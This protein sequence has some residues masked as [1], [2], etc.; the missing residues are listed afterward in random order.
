MAKLRIEAF[1]QRFRPDQGSAGPFVGWAREDTLGLFGCEPALFTD[2]LRSQARS[3]YEGGLIRFLGSGT[4]PPLVGWNG[5]DGWRS[6]WPDIECGLT[7]FGY[8]WMGR[9]YALD[10]GRVI[11][12]EPLVGRLNPA[13]GS[14][15]TSDLTFAEFVLGDLIAYGD[16]ILDRE[17][18]AERQAK[19]AAPLLGTDVVSYAESLSDG[20]SAPTNAELT[21]IEEY[22]ERAGIACA[23]RRGLVRGKAGWQRRQPSRPWWR[24][25]RLTQ[26]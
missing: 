2:F 18:F 7:V 10:S 26:R 3:S 4:E 21:R 13:D 23:E 17:R 14:V 25:G 9:L 24:L 16:R 8:D 20:P 15:R 22:V 12:N 11:Q 1:N 5:P 6:S 19:D